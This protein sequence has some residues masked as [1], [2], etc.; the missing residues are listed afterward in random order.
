MREH[1]VMTSAYDRLTAPPPPPPPPPWTGREGL[2]RYSGREGMGNLR[3]AT[4][5]CL[6]EMLTSPP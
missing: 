6:G 3:H 2:S 4:C 5:V 1:L